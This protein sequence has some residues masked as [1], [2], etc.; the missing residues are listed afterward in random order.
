MGPS[1]AA[2]SLAALASG[3]AGPAFGQEENS[4]SPRIELGSSRIG[5]PGLTEPERRQ[6]QSWSEPP[7]YVTEETLPDKGKP[8]RIPS[9]HTLA[10]RY[11]GGQQ[12]KEAC[13]FYQ[14]ILDEAG[15]E[16]LEAREGAHLRAA[17][18]YFECAEL[19]FAQDDFER[20]EE[21][22][23]MA[24]KLGLRSGRHEVLRRKVVKER[25][26]QKLGAGD[27]ERAHQLYDR[28]QSMGEVDEDERIWFGEQ[29]A[30][31]A[32]DAFARK[33]ELTLRDLMAKLEVIAPM[34]TEYRTLKEELEGDAELFRNIA[35]VVGSAVLAVMLLSALSRWRA[36]ARLRLGRVSSNPFLDDDV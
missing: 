19:A 33:D 16:G 31:L 14:M 5:G 26:R 21:N 32:K 29:L 28:Y 18:A 23:Q 4:T 35:L 11:L 22:L 20:V 15:V 7:E 3:P 27:V 24:E 36:R 1:L 13:R 17:R 9:L 6:V 34:N 8:T 12:W 2:L 25:F 10:E 30:R